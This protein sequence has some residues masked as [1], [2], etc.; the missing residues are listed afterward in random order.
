MTIAEMA[1]AAPKGALFAFLNC[2]SIILEIIN[3]FGPPT[4]R[5]V[6]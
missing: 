6:T 3:P 1:K 2:N 5:G 4:N